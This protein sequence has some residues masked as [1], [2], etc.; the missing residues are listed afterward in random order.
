MRV[1]L[2]KIGN[3]MGIR[4]PQPVI[5]ECSFE[6]ELELVVRQG[7]VVLTPIMKRR[8]GWKE[9]VQDELLHHPVKPEG[10]WEW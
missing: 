8:Q 6:G 9:L 4:L 2:I 1:K 3:S 7:G 10:E 5:K